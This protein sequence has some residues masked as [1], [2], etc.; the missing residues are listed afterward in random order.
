MMFF[1]SLLAVVESPITLGSVAVTRDA[2]PSNC[3]PWAAL[4]GPSANS[5]PRAKPA[6]EPR[7]AAAKSAMLRGF[8]SFEASCVKLASRGRYCGHQAQFGEP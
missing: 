6:A 3:D 2:P 7:L 4:L 1:R 5:G 8:G